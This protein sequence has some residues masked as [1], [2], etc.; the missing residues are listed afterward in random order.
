MTIEVGKY[1]VFGMPPY[2]FFSVL[3]FALSI[4][5]YLVLLLISDT[6]ITK[7]NMFICIFAIIGV[8]VGARIFGC[9]TNIAISLYNN[10]KLGL[11]VI[12]KAGLVYY[13]GL[14][15]CVSF[16][17]IGLKILFK[18]QYDIS[19]VNSLAVCIPLF[20]FFGRLGCLFAGCCYGREYHGY[21]HINYV[22]DGISTETL[23][24]Q[25][26]ES[27]IELGIFCFLL[28]LFAKNKKK[29]N[30]LYIYFLMYSVARFLLE[31][32]RGDSNR[33]FF[34]IL[35]FSQMISI[36]VFIINIF[37]FFRRSHEK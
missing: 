13:G 37:L 15:G 5:C 9:L 34:G 19:L 1:E 27:F 29:K 22:R 4:C 35:S 32:L 7:K 20:H 31:F 23:P 17:C 10:K 21:G 18:T 2:F 12:Y 26:L 33:G 25:L 28:I 11:D 3:G 14:I 16:Y 8:V 24:I 36:L 6:E 30:I